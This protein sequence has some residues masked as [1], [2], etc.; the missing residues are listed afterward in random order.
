MRDAADSSRPRSATRSRCAPRGE[1]V[2][3]EIRLDDLDEALALAR[4][5]EPT[6]AL[7]SRARARLRRYHRRSGRLAQLVRA[8]L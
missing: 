7:S 2:A 4:N 1:E 5:L 6:A 3:V 8:R